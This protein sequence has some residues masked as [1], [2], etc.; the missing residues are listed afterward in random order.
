MNKNEMIAKNL[1]VKF[2]ADNGINLSEP[3]NMKTLLRKLNILTLYLP[4]S[5][6]SYGL[7]LQ[8]QDRKDKF[9]LINCNITRGRQHFT[10]AHEFYHLFYDEHP[11]PHICGLNGQGKVEV[12]KKADAFASALL[13]PSEGIYNILTYRQIEKRSI[14]IADIIY[15]EQYFSVSHQAMVMRLKRLGLITEDELDEQKAL[16]ISDIAPL[17]GF[18]TT[19]YEK[20]NKGLVIGDY[21]MK[22]KRLFDYERISE[23]HYIELMNLIDDGRGR[24]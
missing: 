18:D 9:M 17:Y 1:S 15:M 6:D 7:S 8:S 14:D 4:L 21:G 2:R 12:E 19:L 22:V 10:I 11:E 5:D 13:M 20:G 3:V 16:R 24:N 23:G